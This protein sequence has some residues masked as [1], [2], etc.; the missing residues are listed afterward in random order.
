MDDKPHEGEGE[1]PT[2]FPSASEHPSPWLRGTP[3]SDLQVD[4][5]AF[6][7]ASDSPRTTGPPALPTMLNYVPYRPI[8][9]EQ[10]APTSF[11]E[12]RIGIVHVFVALLFAV[13]SCASVAITY[14]GIGHSWDEA[15]YLKPSQEALTWWRTVFY[16]HTLTQPVNIDKAWGDRLDS[17][18]PLHPEIAPLPKLILGAGNM[19]LGEKLHDP[20]LGMRLPIAALFG[21]T[22]AIAY[23]FGMLEYGHLGGCAAACF[24]WLT[25]RVFGHAHIGASETILAFCTALTCFLFALSTRRGWLAPF[26]GVAFGLAIATKV[27][28][29]ILPFPLFLWGQL[30][31]RRDY[32][33]AM[34]SMMFIG[35]VVAV[36][37]W[38]WLWHDGL[39]RFFSYLLF[40]AQHQSTAVFY[41]GQVWGYTHG[42]PAP[43]HYPW[44]ITGIA[45]PEWLVLLA[46]AGAL[47]AVGQ[48]TFRP[49][50]VLFLMGAL[51]WIAI[52]SIPNAPKYDGERLFYP[53]FFFI[54]LLAAGGFVAVFDLVAWRR[55]KSAPLHRVPFWPLPWMLL[56]ALVSWAA[57]DIYL[58]H[59]NEL[60]YF[61]WAAGRPK[62]A[63]ARGFE[64]SYWGESLNE[65]AT[66]YLRQT[67][68][69]NDRVQ[70]LAMNELC[71]DDLRQWGQLPTN[72]DFNAGEPPLNWIILQVRQGF[73]GRYERNVR[74][75]LK[76]VKIFS[77]QG[78][79]RLEIYQAP[80]MPTTSTVRLET[81]TTSTAQSWRINTD[82]LP[83]I[84]TTETSATT[85]AL[86]RETSAPVSASPQ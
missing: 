79:P 48:I 71:F 40:Y 14:K 13:L 25:P 65:E 4:P 59:P 16:D 35:P 9:P 41:L 23:L 67:L 60:N 37:L 84:G 38:P 19:V 1:K 10:I 33:S 75:T 73:L 70:V 56:G 21:L 24:Y 85:Q 8:E 68:K 43:W 54:A 50:S 81:N 62:G 69:P 53:S 63:Y 83:G 32:A 15:L 44:V 34:F 51:L 18:D 66:A 57:A 58:T 26:V 31:R 46:L 28:S 30:Y 77:A 49:V 80:A 17:T 72:V 27:T 74:A 3:S 20:L 76:P 36:A 86:A 7:G 61:N 2:A 78:V 42:P 82:K 45:T 29:L 5:P 11:F 64:T 52:S 22:V 6:A 47:R 12:R 39:L 55:R